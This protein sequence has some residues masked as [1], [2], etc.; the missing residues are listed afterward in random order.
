MQRKF[1]GVFANAQNGFIPAE[2]CF[3][4]ARRTKHLPVAKQTP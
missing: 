1:A 2:F 3:A 4:A